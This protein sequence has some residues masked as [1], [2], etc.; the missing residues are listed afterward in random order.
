VHGGTPA[1]IKVSRRRNFWQD[2]FVAEAELPFPL[3]P[4]RDMI[5]G[6]PEPPPLNRAGF[7]FYGFGNRVSAPLASPQQRVEAL[8]SS[9]P[10][11]SHVTTSR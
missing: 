5:K 4:P 1:T 9:P 10:P 11:V 6:F 2:G 3:R 7:S 8:E